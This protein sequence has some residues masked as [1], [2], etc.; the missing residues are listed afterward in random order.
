MRIRYG[1]VITHRTANL[2]SRCKYTHG[3]ATMSALQPPAIYAVSF[4]WTYVLCYAA[5]AVSSWAFVK[6]SQRAL[7]ERTPGS[8]QHDQLHQI[9]TDT[10]DNM[11]ARLSKSA[12]NDANVI[13]PVCL[14]S[15]P[16]PPLS[17]P[18]PTC[19]HPSDPY[20][21]LS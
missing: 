4:S 3:T 14:I 16:F 7:D 17:L 9:S 20:I 2:F 8:Y 10:I 18:H 21:R 12:C 1:N 15:D 5:R 11:R 13:H 6:F 19:L